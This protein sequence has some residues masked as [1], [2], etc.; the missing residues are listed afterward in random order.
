MKCPHCNK[1]TKGKKGKYH[2]TESGLDNVYLETFIYKC[3]CGE[4][5]VD[6]PNIYGLHE[7]IAKDLVRKKSTLRGKEIKFIRKQL[8]LKANELAQILG[9]NKVTVSRWENEEENIGIA[10]D[11]LI[12]MIYIQ[13]CQEK[14][15]EIFA[16][17]G[18]IRT[19]DAS[20][21]KSK[22]IIIPQKDI[23]NAI[24]CF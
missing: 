6:I 21:V 5:I 23:K 18:S 16:I 4:T 8:H 12:R 3:E 10:N 2:Y 15:K 17:V 7:L 19:I 22:N 20:M 14:C 11:K 13:M 24:S 1:A 9:V